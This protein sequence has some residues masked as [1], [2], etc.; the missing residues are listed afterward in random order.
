MRFIMV[1]QVGGHHASR[2]PSSA[3][4]RYSFDEQEVDNRRQGLPG[5]AE[6]CDSA[7]FWSVLEGNDS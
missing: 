2:F 1:W 4:C 7:G 3:A 5:F 6:E